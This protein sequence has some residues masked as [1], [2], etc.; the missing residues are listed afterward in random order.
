MTQK[1]LWS[2][3]KFMEMDGAKG[4]LI[5]SQIFVFAPRK[6]NERKKNGNQRF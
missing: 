2:H 6:E 3:T 4:H 1:T 5:T